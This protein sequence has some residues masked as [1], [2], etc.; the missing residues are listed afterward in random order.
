MSATITGW[1]RGSVVAGPDRAALASWTPGPVTALSDRPLPYPDAHAVVDFDVR[2]ELG[3]RGTSFLDR[4]TSL[5]VVACRDALADAGLEPDDTNRDRIGVALGTTV[6]SFKSTSEF[7]LESKISEK[8]YLVNPVLFPNTVMNCAA[9][10]A[11]IRFGLRGVNATVAGGPIGF[12][13]ALRYATNALERGYAGAML[14][15]AAEEFSEHRAWAHALSTTEPKPVSVGEAA[16]V[17]VVEASPAGRSPQADV[18]AVCT[19]YGPAGGRERALRSC[20]RRALRAAGV[21]REEV[22][23]VVTGEADEADESEYQPVTGVLG[24]RVPRLLPRVYFGDCGAATGGLGVGLLLAGHRG[25]E[26]SPAGAAL[27]TGCDDDGAVAVAV[28]RVVRA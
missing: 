23:A 13:I 15:G 4:A 17:F 21:G 16:V 7:S 11:A 9:G 14:V 10:Q 12:L 6:G 2:A 3:R 8:P 27:V 24:D 25:I 20:T 5:A 1:S 18:L 22:V 19:G 26:P 28:I